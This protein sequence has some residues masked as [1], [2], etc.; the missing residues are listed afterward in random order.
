MTCWVCEETVEDRRLLASCDGCG[1]DY[2]LNPYQTP[3]KDC[4]D[5]SIDSGLEPTLDFFCRP[6]ME[7]TTAQLREA[8]AA[9]S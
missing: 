2:H 8:R 6:C 5:A 3:G 9:G 1:Q 4:G 7:G